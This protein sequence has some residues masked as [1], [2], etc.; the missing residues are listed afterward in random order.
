MQHRPTANQHN[1]SSNRPYHQLHMVYNYAGNIENKMLCRILLGLSGIWKPGYPTGIETG[2]RAP[3]Y[4]FRA[5]PVTVPDSLLSY[6]PKLFLH[7]VNFFP[8]DLI[9]AIFDVYLCIFYSVSYIYF[10]NSSAVAEMGDRLATIDMGRKVGRGCCFSYFCVCD[11][12]LNCYY[13]TQQSYPF[14]HLGLTSF[15]RITKF[16]I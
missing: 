4:L 13:F 5:L 8:I 10:N 6:R 7:I 15:R 1:R 9:R 11:T 3:V 16:T 12:P 2:T 14:A